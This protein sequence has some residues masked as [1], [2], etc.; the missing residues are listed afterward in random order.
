[1]SALAILDMEKFILVW[2]ALLVLGA[3]LSRRQ[4]YGL[5]SSRGWR[6]SARFPKRLDRDKSY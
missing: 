1:M 6:H 2:A 4:A 3:A 5:D